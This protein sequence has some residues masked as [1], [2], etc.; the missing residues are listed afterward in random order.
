MTE[1]DS[2]LVP[3][4]CPSCGA[5]VASTGAHQVMV[6]TP[7]GTLILGACY[8]RHLCLC[9]AASESR[10]TKTGRLYLVHYQ[11]TDP[12]HYARSRQL[13]QNRR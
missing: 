2:R 4:H 1:S 11:R 13:K 5:Q 9:G 7:T 8:A 12:P 6:E 10:Q 3:M